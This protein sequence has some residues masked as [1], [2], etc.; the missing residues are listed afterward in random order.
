MESLINHLKAQSYKKYIALCLSGAGANVSR[1][2]P[3]FDSFNENIPSITS[4]TSRI[5][6]V[7]K[8]FVFLNEEGN[9]TNLR[10]MGWGA[11]QTQCTWLRKKWTT[12][13][14]KMIFRKIRQ[15]FFITNTNISQSIPLWTI[16]KHICGTIMFSSWQLEYCTNKK[17][18]F[19]YQSTKPKWKICR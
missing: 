9:K 1:F 11:S 8:H 15:R 19:D 10:G 6:K 18:M 12:E 16:L 3:T 14:S 13:N 17:K 5:L 4:F 2:R 7:L